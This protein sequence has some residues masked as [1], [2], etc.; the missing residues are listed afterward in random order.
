MKSTF[1]ILALLVLLATNTM[2]ARVQ[3][4]QKWVDEPL[5]VQVMVHA[6][7]V[8]AE[9]N[10]HVSVTIGDVTMDFLGAGCGTVTNAY[11]TNVFLKP[12]QT[13]SCV[14]KGTNLDSLN[15]SF[16]I[17]PPLSRL[18]LRRRAGSL[19]KTYRVLV[20]SA[21]NNVITAGD[22]DCLY[23]SQEFLLEVR[24]TPQPGWK[25]D[26][27]SSGPDTAPGDAP[28]VSIGPGKSLAYTDTAIDWNVSL[29]HLI[30]GNA[31]GKLRIRQ[32]NLTNG[33]Y[34]PAALFYTAKS[35]NI[36]AQI[37]FI[38]TNSAIAS[39]RQIM[40][41]Q[42]FV[43][44]VPI[45]TNSP[46][47]EMRFYHPGDIGANKGTNGLYTNITGTAFVTYLVQNPDT[48]ASTRL[49]LVEKRNGIN[50]TNQVI[51]S[52]GNTNQTWALKYG[53]GSEERIE[54][55]GVLLVTNSSPHYINR[56]E[57]VQIKYTASGSPLAYEC[58][59]TYRLYDWGWELI[60]VKTDPNGAALTTTFDYYEDPAAPA[61]YRRPK[62]TVYPDG[63]WE[64]KE[65]CSDPASDDPPYGAMQYVL[66]PWMDSPA[67]PNL[68]DHATCLVT[69]Y[70][71]GAEM[72]AYTDPFAPS[73]V[74]Q[75]YGVDGDTLPY[76]IK[77]DFVGIENP[78]DNVA[79][80]LNWQMIAG[81]DGTEAGFQEYRY[82]QKEAVG[83]A[84]KT[85]WKDNNS[86]AIE[87][88]FYDLGTYNPT[89][90]LFNDAVNTTAFRD[91]CIHA[92]S[93]VTYARYPTAQ[94]VVGDSSHDETFGAEGGRDL[95][96]VPN[97]SW[98]ETKITDSCVPVLTERY[99]Y[100]GKTVDDLA[101]FS[102]IDQQLI[103]TDS[104]GH[105]TNIV[106]YDAIYT[107]ATR[108]VYSSDWKGGGSVDGD[109]KLSETDE[110]GVKTLFAYDSLK[111][112]NSITKVGISNVT[113]FP[114]QT[115]VVIS[116][117]S[118]AYGRDVARITNS[119]SLSITNSRTYDISGRLTSLVDSNLFTSSYSYATDVGTTVTNVTFSRS[120]NIT[121]HY[122]DRRLRSIT[123]S[124]VVAEFHSYENNF[125]SPFPAA[126]G[127]A[128]NALRQYETIHFGTTNSSR[129]QQIGMD[130]I[131]RPVWN[132]QPGFTGT[133]IVV[134]RTHYALNG[135]SASPSATRTLTY[136]FDENEIP[137]ILSDSDAPYSMLYDYDANGDRMLQ[138]TQGDYGETSSLLEASLHRFTRTDNYFEL[139]GSGHWF[140]V[141]TNTVFLTD[142]SSNR[143]A[144]SI[145]K[146]RLNG[147]SSSNLVSEITTIN[148][149]GNST[150]NTRTVDRANMKLTETVL[151]PESNL[152]ATNITLNALLQLSNTPTVAEPVRFFYDALG[153]QVQMQNPAGYSSFQYWDAIT[154]L[155][156]N[157]VDATGRSTSYEYYAPTN[158]NAG[159]LKCRT[160]A[161]GK[162]S[163]LDYNARGQLSR[164][165]GDVPYPEERVYS[166]FG[167]LTE[168]RTFRGGS[169][170]SGSSWPTGNSYDS[171][172]WTYQAGSGLLL[173]KTDAA[174]H[175]VQYEY[176][177]WSRLKTTKWARGS[178]KTNLYDPNGP[179]RRIDYSDTNMIS[180]VFTNFSR[181]SLA[182]LVKD[183]SGDHTLTYDNSGRLI[184]DS[185]NAGFLNGI[186][187]N[188]GFNSLGQKSS[189]SGLGG[190]GEYFLYDSRGRLGVVS[191]GVNT[192]T[193]AYTAGLE[194]WTSL[195]NKSTNSNPSISS[196]TR[197]FEFGERLQTIRNN[198]GTV[199]VA[200]HNYLYDTMGR[201]QR[202]I[203]EDSSWWTYGYDD[204]DQVVSGKRSWSDFSPVPG[205]QFEY[206]FDNIGNRTSSKAGGDASGLP[207]N[208]RTS[209]YSANNLNQYTNVVTP[210]ALDVIGATY[211]TASIAVNS[212]TNVYRKGEYFQKM[213]AFN[214]TNAPV[215]C[216]LTSTATLG[217][218]PP[219]SIVGTNLLT[220]NQPA[221]TYDLDG[222]LTQDGLW[223][224]NWDAEN[225][226]IQ[227]TN[228]AAVASNVA[229]KLVFDYDN[230]GRRVR[231]R[232]YPWASTNWST[233]ASL[234]I[235]FVYDDWLL[236]AEIKSSDNSL[237]RSYSWGLDLSGRGARAGGVGGLV[238]M[239]EHTN[240]LAAHFPAYDG[241]GNV[242]ALVKND[243]TVSARYEYS[244]FGELLRSSGL[245]AVVNPFR[246][247]TKFWDQDAGMICYGFRYFCP[248]LGRWLGRDPLVD[249]GSNNAFLFC[250]NSPVM[251]VDVDGR[252]T[253]SFGLQGTFGAGVGFSGGVSVA[254]G[255]S[256]ADG[257][258][259]GTHYNYGGGLLLGY[260]ASV[261]VVG[262]ITTATSVRTL[263]G[264]STEFGCSGGVYGDA[265]YSLITNNIGNAESYAGGE[266]AVGI[267]SSA[268]VHAF[269]LHEGGL[270]FLDA[271]GDS[272]V[273]F[274]P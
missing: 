167:E 219:V 27:D 217:T 102:L 209:S 89:N 79:I 92:V 122:R 255:Y 118:D 112:L 172:T 143:T 84:D 224:Y 266:L 22:G 123:G 93:E 100:T 129:W 34:T 183:A 91:S 155:L 21:L 199:P 120:T 14:V 111:R 185:G 230:H 137:T 119:G 186:T 260:A 7:N 192:C 144:L 174:S 127:D 156:T 191:N 10:S 227:M 52:S 160:A 3:P 274:D 154:S 235:K 1:R 215:T 63:F 68:A 153:R 24:E 162:K 222:N 43:D 208:L 117:L 31:A 270:T 261:S 273:V 103:K 190:F 184:T 81:P 116:L 221:F 148:T 96:L 152:V 124:G 115:S 251:V 2:G 158:A 86:G 17:P 248:S 15:I 40:A 49:F 236:V 136:G 263:T 30:N 193:Y 108:V 259:F 13:Y 5:G 257:W 146:E 231:K 223:K 166:D 243:A 18:D 233:T 95:H 180:V 25:I 203:L 16:E 262:Q 151:T 107:N 241:N 232:V 114:N 126:T 29:G 37:E 173:S 69:R 272:D 264:E 12:T 157:V 134:N 197:T 98:K 75:S 181:A 57:N 206:A 271:F 32:G 176:D 182:R 26:E 139:N 168:L 234:D 171:T 225:R 200:S 207:V 39:L 44:I 94:T 149:D 97:Q 85:I 106:R 77:L 250:N 133:N 135:I 187:L 170:W 163:Y 145:S 62:S 188:F 83:W 201:R 64:L 19:P 175:T 164:T 59:E 247:S 169:G 99:V 210:G 4:W 132:E 220:P 239:L 161:N 265:G 179:I 218:N 178:N 141:A 42:C 202:A 28:W 76:E 211:A 110:F 36:K 113:G 105:V 58:K 254:I 9:L 214:N 101:L 142:N 73:V 150:V 140:K 70:A 6:Y 196:T 226:L 80:V 20:D 74:H 246:F 53:T 61:S 128:S 252:W 38:S 268:E 50:R 204:R 267:G 54:S 46:Q 245:S 242:V 244:P 147:F 213:L 65:Y 194:P 256:K 41:P 131:G 87:A 159:L 51:Y 195:S 35:T 212:N 48:N 8:F 67:T 109:L 228:V 45:A 60:E 121:S 237:I 138:G 125:I 269:F 253:L 130:W 249:Q 66:S 33:I 205:Q 177:L 90:R 55:R 11:T 56:Y 238:L 88:H 78:E 258:T 165:W 240:S 47:F 72:Q 198:L 189:V 216:V 71:Y 23:Y 104:L 82:T 229:R